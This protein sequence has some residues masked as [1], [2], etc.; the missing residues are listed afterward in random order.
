VEALDGNSIA[1]A[2]NQLFRTE[3]TTATGACVHCGAIAQIAELRVYSRAPGAVVRCRNCGN[4]V[5]VLVQTRGVTRIHL[6]GFDL[7]DDPAGG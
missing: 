7:I 5:F 6:G 2:L 1:G 4:V 3:M